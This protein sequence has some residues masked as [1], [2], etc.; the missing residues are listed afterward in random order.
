MRQAELGRGIRL[1]AD[2]HD[3]LNAI[4]LGEMLAT[5]AAK[6]QRTQCLH[7][8]TRVTPVANI[9]SDTGEG[10]TEAS[11]T[12]RSTSFGMMKPLD[13]KSGLARARQMS[14]PQSKR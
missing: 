12:T 11:D 10:K 9:P 14:A 6:I 2:E 1:S 4:G 13:A 7:R 3:L 8:S 5:E